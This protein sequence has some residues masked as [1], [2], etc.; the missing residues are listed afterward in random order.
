M[1]DM[2]IKCDR[3]KCVISPQTK[4]GIDWMKNNVMTIADSN[5]AVIDADSV[6]D[7]ETCLDAAGIT[8]RRC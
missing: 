6:N 3:F 2:L 5:I 7:F 4:D 8:Y 1:T